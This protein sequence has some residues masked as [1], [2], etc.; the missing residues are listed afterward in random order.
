[1]GGGSGGRWEGHAGTRRRAGGRRAGAEGRRGSRGRGGDTAASARRGAAGAGGRA[2]AGTHLKHHDSTTPSKLATTSGWPAATRGREGGGRGGGG[3]WRS[4]RPTAWARGVGAWR[5]RAAWARRTRAPHARARVAPARLNA[6]CLFSTSYLASLRRG[7]SGA[8]NPDHRAEAV[9]AGA[10]V[11]CARWPGWACRAGGC[12][13]SGVG[14]GRKLTAWRA[15][16]R[17]RATTRPRPASRRTCRRSRGTPASSPPAA[18]RPSRR[19]G[20]RARA[21]RRAAASPAAS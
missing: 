3:R 19:C 10:A 14:R 20:G 1:M 12:G 2:R 5:G 18:G 16:T 6:G 4:G 11:V 17:S 7:R 15:P 9:G 13:G 8:V 21:C